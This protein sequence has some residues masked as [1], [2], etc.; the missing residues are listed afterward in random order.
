MS[1]DRVIVAAGARERMDRLRAKID[2]A[3][4]KDNPLVSLI[5]QFQDGVQLGLKM[6]HP[7]P[8]MTAMEAL[9][10][11][12][13][14]VGTELDITLP[15]PVDAGTLKELTAREMEVLCWMAQGYRNSAIAGF[16]H[17]EPK[18]VER[19]INSIYSKLSAHAEGRH[20][21]VYTVLLYRLVLDKA[22]GLA[23][24]PE[25]IRGA[26]EAFLAARDTWTP[27]WSASEL[28]QAIVEGVARERS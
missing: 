2:A 6:D 1:D 5:L 18:S 10:R 23:W 13:A 22:L 20:M 26:I 16:M 14:H 19:H 11:F 9:G 28:A 3:M 21:R 25:E 27:N 8:Q 17:L 24:N 15:G 4:A 7:I 12:A